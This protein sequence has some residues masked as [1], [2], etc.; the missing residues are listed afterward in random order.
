M[1]SDGGDQW[2]WANVRIAEGGWRTTLPATVILCVLLAGL[3]LLAVLVGGH[4]LA[5]L[6]GLLR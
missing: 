1:S 6:L 2:W 4:V 5:V 3:A